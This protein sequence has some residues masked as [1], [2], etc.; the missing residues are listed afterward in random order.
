MDAFY[1]NVHVLDD[2]HDA[3]LPLVIGGQPHERGVVASASYEARHLG[4]CSAMPTSTA[5][6]ICPT[7]KIVP[8]VG[9]QLVA[10]WPRIRQCSQ[11]VMAVLTDYGPV[12]QVSVDEAYVELDAVLGLDS[13]S[14]YWYEE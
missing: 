7:L 6:R 10:N 11:Q 9:G 2:R 5:V 3:G 13:R 8:P 14:W 12:E 4:I 1:V